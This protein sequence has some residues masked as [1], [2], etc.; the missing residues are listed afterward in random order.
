MR[1]HLIAIVDHEKRSRGW[2]PYFL[3]WFDRAELLIES[4][5]STSTS[6]AHVQDCDSSRPAI[7]S[8]TASQIVTEAAPGALLCLE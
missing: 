6:M 2:T 5:L 8:Y 3:F 4:I 1:T 7:T